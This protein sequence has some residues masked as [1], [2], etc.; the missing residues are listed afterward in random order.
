[1]AWQDIQKI[2]E[3]VP[4]DQPITSIVLYALF[5]GKSV[6]TPAFLLAVLKH[7]GLLRPMKGKKRCHEFVDPNGFPA[8]VKKL[9]SSNAKP[10][11]PAR[12]PPVKKA[13][14][15]ARKTTKKATIRKKASTSRRK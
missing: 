2:L 10:K 4:K 1:M 6:N 14:N 12:K 13:T 7:E 15:T 8:K 11:Q 3:K 9:M 5:K